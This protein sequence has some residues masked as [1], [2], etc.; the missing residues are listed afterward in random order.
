LSYL[1]ARKRDAKDNIIQATLSWVF[2]SG[3]RI[4]P[5][6]AVLNVFRLGKVPGVREMIPWMKHEKNSMT[7]L[8][9][10]K[11][12]GR[13]ENRAMPAQVVHDFIDKAAIHV[14]MDA[15]GCR[16]AGNCR[17]FTSSVGCLFMGDTALK[18]PHGVSRR[19]TR[20]EAHRHVE[21]AVEVGLVPMTGKVRVDN[22]IFLTPDENKLLSVCFCCPCCCMMTAFK[23]IPGEYLDGIMPRM[24][25]L[26]ITVTDA[27]TG[28]GECLKTCG[29]GA[30]SIADGRARH[31]NQCRGCGRCERTCPNGA[32]RIN[33]TNENYIEDVSRRISSYVDFK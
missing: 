18:M 27:C 33:I 21:R 2:K 6:M 16:L 17:H 32:V 5:T 1:S 7:Y 3:R 26:E 4:K 11:S 31:N 10:N 14:I 9:I 22:F 24:E 29:F 12:L 23:H 19:V 8:P 15:C 28:C 13:Y 25:G 20:E 30:I